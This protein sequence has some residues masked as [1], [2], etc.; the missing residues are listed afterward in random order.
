MDIVNDFQQAQ[1]D[2]LN[3]DNHTNGTP[4]KK[5]TYKFGEMWKEKDQPVKFLV[6]D[7][8]PDG[9]I[10][11]VIG[12]DGIG[13]TRLLSQLL[14]DITTGKTHFLGLEL[15]APHKR[16]LFV[17]TEDGRLKFIRAAAK[18]IF[19]MEGS[20]VNP[21]SIDLSFTEGVDFDSMD[22][23]E[24]EIIRVLKEGPVD[25]I[26]VDAMSDLFGLIDGEINS[27]T[28]ARKIM[29]V[30]GRIISEYHVAIILI[31]H[32]AKTKIDALRKEGKLFLTKNVSQGAGAITQRPRT[33]LAITHDHNSVEGDGARYKNYLHV[34]KANVMGKKFVQNAIELSFDTGNLL[35]FPTGVLV[36]IQ[37]HEN[38]NDDGQE[39]SRKAMESR[40]ITALSL[41]LCMQSIFKAKKVLSRK[42][43][44]TKMRSHL[45]VT[46]QE[47]IQHGGYLQTALFDALAA[48][49]PP[50]SIGP[51]ARLWADELFNDG[52]QLEDAPF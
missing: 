36:D 2:K 8:I 1:L 40:E 31:H 21:D 37:K 10:T 51:G 19:A 42:D 41:R 13:K 22:A 18:Q 15:N 23:L 26:V 29:A 28:H 33:V 4:A 11:L 14:L 3:G 43:V 5:S 50:E 7:L 35:H 20:D 27:N 47:I 48:S 34:V 45:G 24:A 9:E 17:S 39:D 38:A 16:A 6:P 32:A 52:E 12:E 30:L 25:A 44:I 46:E 49:I